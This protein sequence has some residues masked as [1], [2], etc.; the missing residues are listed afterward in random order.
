MEFSVNRD[1]PFIIAEV[2]QAHEGSLGMAHAYIDAVAATG[3]DAIKF[4]THYAVD[5]SSIYDKFRVDVFPQDESRFEYWKRMEFSEEQWMELS[6]HCRGKDIT[7]LSSPFSLRATEV[8]EKCGVAAWKIASGEWDNQPMIDRLMSTKKPLL[9][10]TGMASWSEI[11]DFV[12]QSKASNKVLFQCTSEY[13]SKPETIGLNNISMFR[14]K[15]PGIPIGLSDHSGNIFPS[16]AAFALGTKFFEVHVCFSKQQFGPDTTSSLVMSELE[17]LVRGLKFLHSAFSS[18]VDKDVER[19]KKTEM[20]E[21]FGRGIFAK[22]DI[23]KGQTIDE[24]MLTFLKP[25]IGISASEYKNIIG[26]KCRKHI[27]KNEP[28]QRDEIL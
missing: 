27:N 14:E 4:Q 1:A 21:L 15:F 24:T 8:L 7:F 9:I 3:A 5:E 12:E 2:G 28:I 13:P 22:V 17:Q 26:K 19:K 6:R 16:T 10:S 11:S 20:R 25:Q 23:I 18:D